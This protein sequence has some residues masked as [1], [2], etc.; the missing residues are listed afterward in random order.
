EYP[1][2][3]HLPKMRLKAV[4]ADGHVTSYTEQD[5]VALDVIS[6]RKTRET[7]GIDNSNTPGLFFVPR[8]AVE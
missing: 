7:F 3:E 8:E 5:V 1:D 2:V 4:F 6:N